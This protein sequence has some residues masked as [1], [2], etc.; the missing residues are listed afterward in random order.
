MTVALTAEAGRLV[1]VT[2][3]S[4]WTGS[5]SSW[6][7]MACS[8]SVRGRA[9][10][11]AEAFEDVFDAF[12][13]FGA[14]LDEQVGAGAAR[15]V[16]AAG[17]GH[18]VAVLF[19]GQTGC[20]K[21][22]TAWTGFDDDGAEREARDDAVAHGEGRGEGFEADGQFADE[23]TLSDD[24]VGEFVVFWGVDIA[25]AAALYG[26]GSSFGGEGATVGG[27]VDAPRQARDHGEPRGGEQVCQSGGL[28][29]AVMAGVT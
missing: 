2:S 17:D 25:E 27:C 16:D 4:T 1:R 18:D 28:F 29:L 24:L 8:G 14:F 21:C 23:G 22:S 6:A 3:W 5:W 13:E 15:R 9:A 11:L 20:D 26:D 7:R 10:Y 12:D 19:D